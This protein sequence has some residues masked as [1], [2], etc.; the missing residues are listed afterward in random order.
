MMASVLAEG[1]TLGLSFG[2]AVIL[3]AI[4]SI[5]VLLVS[6][7]A[8]TRTKDPRRRAF[9][10]AAAAPLVTPYAFN[11]D[12]TALTVVLTWRL[13]DQAP[14]PGSPKALLFRL[15]W[16]APIV[17]MALNMA[18]IGVAPVFFI[19]VFV[20]A[21]REAC[22]PAPATGANGDD[23]EHARAPSVP[24]IA[25]RASSAAAIGAG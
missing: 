14:V 2:V 4:V 22:E 15:A 6:A 8:V 3:Q 7:W 24:P 21:A 20:I 1:R 10:L 16:L 9:V 18:R 25:T 5:P 12:L 13:I 23:A 11:Y 19:A 17:L